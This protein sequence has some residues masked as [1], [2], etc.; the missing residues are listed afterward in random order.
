[1]ATRLF[2][3]EQKPGGITE[4]WYSDERGHITRRLTQD[5]ED[6]IKGIAAAAE[7]PGNEMRLLGSVPNVLALEW[8]QKIGH[9]IGSKEWLDYAKKQLMS[10]E[11]QSLST[12][13]KI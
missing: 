5:C 8:S 9:G 4:K 10:N 2:H 6:L 13:V 12:G 7:N 1:M 3:Q 11:F